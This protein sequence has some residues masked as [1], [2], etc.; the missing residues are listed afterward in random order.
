MNQ[1][2]R[3]MI[4]AP[5]SGTGKTAIT[6]GLLKVLEQRGISCSSFKCGPD[7]IDPM[8][9]QYVQGIPG[10]NLD[11]YFLSE[12]GVQRLLIRRM[13]QKKLAVLEGVMGYYDGVAGI[14]TRASSYDIARITDTPVILVVDGKKSSLSM[15]ALIQ[16]F[17]HY[18][19]DSR[20]CGVILNRTSRMM[21]ERLREPIEALGVHLLGA[22]PE[23]GA[24]ELESRHLGLTLPHEQKQ[25]QEKISQLA[26]ILDDCLDIEKIISLANCAPALVP[27]A[28]PDE[29]S[30]AEIR[31]EQTGRIGIAM[32]E[33]FCFYYQE[34][35]GFL[36]DCGY[37]LI[38]FSPMHDS[39]L[40]GHLDAV[41]LGGGYPEIYAR[42]LSQNEA[43]LS[44][45]RTAA[46]SG[47]KLLAECGGFLYLHQTLE[48]TDGNVWPMAGIIPEHAFKTGQLSRFGYIELEGDHGRIRAHEFHYWDSSDP[49]EA[50]CARK[51]MSSRSWN[52]MYRS[53]AMMV[54]FPHLYYLSS[55]ELIRNFLRST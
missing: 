23:C 51:P 33:A 25:L 41:L 17:L 53:E 26:A 13:A 3:I 52:C 40:P 1:L 39:E 49:G 43:M 46:A 37:T 7:Y 36:R 18:R 4:A 34:N 21:A 29:M 35:L 2:P 15:A 45:I 10:C 6:C 48:D 55:P 32:D 16:G 50:M 24:A 14:S 31:L 54:G 28:E 38:P 20:I 44:S 19:K 11:S 5:A 22:V 30:P 9:H 8:F 47:M 12:A 42:Q 27:Q